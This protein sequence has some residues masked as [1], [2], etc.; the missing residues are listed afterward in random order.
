AQ[1]PLAP[2]DAARAGA[3]RLEDDALVDRLEEG[4]ELAGGAGQLEGVAFLGD[5][6]DAAAE[7]LRHPLH[8][9]AL[10]ADRAYLDEHE[11]ALGVGALGQVDHLHHLDQAVQVLGDLLDHLVGAGGDDRHA[12]Q[13]GILGRCDGQGLDVVAAGGKEADHARQGAGFVFQEDCDDVLHRS[14]EPSS[15]S[16]MPLPALTIGQT[17]SVWSVWTSRNTVRSLRRSA[18]RSAGSTSLGLSIRMPTWPYASASL[19]KSG[20][21]SM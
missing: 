7:D 10:L 21:A 15:I 17:F 12:R 13:R 19:T 4:V 9:V 5:V 3:H 2:A 18:S 20:S 1:D 11:L 14:S 6:D 8:L 16:V